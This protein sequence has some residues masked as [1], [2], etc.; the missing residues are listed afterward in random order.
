MFIWVYVVTS[1]TYIPVLFLTFNVRVL[2]LYSMPLTRQQLNLGLAGLFDSCH[3]S[4]SI[5][6]Y[7]QT[8]YATCIYIVSLILSLQY[9]NSTLIDVKISPHLP[10]L[11]IHRHGTSLRINKYFHFI[12]WYKL[13]HWGNRSFDRQDIYADISTVYTSWNKSWL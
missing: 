3:S 1:F 4:E 11:C 9:L 2:F 12:R 13:W 5:H 6:T 7:L 10:Q 8:H